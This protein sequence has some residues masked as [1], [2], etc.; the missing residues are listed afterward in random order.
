MSWRRNGFTRS[1]ATDAGRTETESA[2]YTIDYT[3]ID[4]FKKI[5]REQK[6][7]ILVTIK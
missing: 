4:S 7:R 1:E 3:S 6:I 2:E 5:I